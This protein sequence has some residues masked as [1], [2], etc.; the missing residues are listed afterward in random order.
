M[1]KRVAIIQGHPDPAGGHFCHAM[2]DAY[3]SGAIAAHHAVTRVDIAQIDFPLLR[4][5]ADFESGTLPPSLVPARDAIVNSDHL[6]FVFPL[7]LGTMPALVKAFL[8]QVLRPGIGFSYRDGALPKK[9]LAGRSARIIVTMGMPAPVYRW[10]FAEDGIRGLRRGILHFVGIR[11]IKTTYVG[12]IA[13]LSDQKRTA[14]LE[15]CRRWGR[16]LA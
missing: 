9:L 4:T 2:A 1:P 12:T 3:A 14:W 11:P 15:Q 16:D 10:F 5:F 6:L 13:G 8:E 7:W